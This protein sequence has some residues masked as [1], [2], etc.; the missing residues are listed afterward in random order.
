MFH[1]CDTMERYMETFV[2]QLSHALLVGMG[3]AVSFP[4]WWYTRGVRRVLGWATRAL[5][6]WEHAVGLRLWMRALLVPMYGQTDLQG[7]LV[8]FAMRLAVLVGRVVQ[9]V[10]GTIVVLIAVLGYLA[11]PVLAGAGLIWSLLR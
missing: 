7:R 5:R 4:W 8:S 11:L 9:V 1:V 3:E 10:L 2:V 6:G